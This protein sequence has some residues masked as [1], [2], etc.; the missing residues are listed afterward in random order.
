MPHLTAAEADMLLA[1]TTGVGVFL[2]VLFLIYGFRYF[3]RPM[4]EDN[5]RSPSIRDNV[6]KVK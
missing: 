4:E 2:A 6:Y 1:F 5:Y 3:I